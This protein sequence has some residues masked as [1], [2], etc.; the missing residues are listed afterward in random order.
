MAGVKGIRLSGLAGAVA[1]AAVSMLVLSAG[2]N[3]DNSATDEPTPEGKG[4]L[5]VDNRTGDRLS[6]FVSGVYT[7][8]VAAASQTEVALAPGLYRVVVDQDDGPRSFRDDVDI[9]RG[10]RT[11]LHVE[12]SGTNGTAYAVTMEFD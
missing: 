9:L 8:A 12:E 3:E 6:V 4:A 5:V 7:A 1:A 10:R 11:W 2:C